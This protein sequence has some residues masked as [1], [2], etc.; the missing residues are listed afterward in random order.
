MGSRAFILLASALPLCLAACGPIPRDIESTEQRLRDGKPLAA[1]IVA[2]PGHDAPAIAAAQAVADTMGT[3]ATIEMGSAERLLPKL[4]EGELDVIVG[5]FAMKS[6]WAK[7]VTFSRA[8]GGM[9]AP[10]NEPALRFANRFGENRWAMT[11]DSA[12]VDVADA[13]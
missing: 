12:A 9:T 5:S 7:R 13:R 10:K 11:L 6:P 4:E 8:I 2:E 3:T 1:G